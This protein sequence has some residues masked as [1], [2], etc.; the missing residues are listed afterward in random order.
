M[1]QSFGFS[2]DITAS[3]SDGQSAD[4]SVAPGTYHVTEAATAG[5]DLTD[6]SCD[7]GASSGNTAT[8]VATFVVTAGQHV[9]CTYT[10]TKRATIT[11]KKVTDP[12][13]AQQS[14]GFSGDITASLSDGQSADSSVAPGTY[15]VTEAAT[16]GWDLT[17]ISCDHGASSG[18]TATGVAT[19]VVT[20]G[21]HV[22]CTYTNTKRAT[23]TVKKVTDPAGAQQSFGFSGDITASLSDGQSADSSVAPGTYHVT[24]AATAGWDLTDISCDHGASSGNTAT[25]V[26]TFVV[27]AGQHVTCTYTNTKRATITVKKVTDPA[28][29]QQSFGFSGDIT[30][31]F[32]MASRP[33]VRS[34]RAPTT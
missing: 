24:E 22:T 28:G 32:R 10:N 7:H 31:S 8:G 29:D 4:S 9:T 20:A 2:G 12:A 23:I 1:Q 14:F 11:V 18:N 34:L 19:F 21:Q 30:A 27:T 16:A 33:T 6:I 17:N 26:A 3:L 15:H 13:G 5:W 25:G